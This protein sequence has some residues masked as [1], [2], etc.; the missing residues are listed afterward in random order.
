MV[1]GCNELRCF[2][3]FAIVILH[4]ICAA[5]EAACVVTALETSGIS[6]LV[7]FLE[8]GDASFHQVSY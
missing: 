1:Y 8:A 3:E 2:R 6:H 7:S 4:A 5:S